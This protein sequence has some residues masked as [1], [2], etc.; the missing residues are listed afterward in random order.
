MDGILLTTRGLAVRWR[1]SYNT[2]VNWRALRRGPRFVKL[3]KY[4]TVRY[5][6]ADIVRYERDRLVPARRARG[7]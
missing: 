6:L 7:G 2:L 3:S 5:R 4:G 1:M